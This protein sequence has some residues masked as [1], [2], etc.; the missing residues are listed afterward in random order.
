M[1]DSLS[2]PVSSLPSTSEI[3]FCKFDLV[4]PA[5]LR[6]FVACSFSLEKSCEIRAEDAGKN[7]GLSMG[8][9][10]RCETDM[11]EIEQ[12]V[13]ASSV[14][15]EIGGVMS[16]NSMTD[17]RLGKQSVDFGKYEISLA[18]LLP[19]GVAAG[20]WGNNVDTWTVCGPD[21]TM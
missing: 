17:F 16:D 7:F 10:C 13:H 15:E 3:P 1:Q 20:V 5:A 4:R 6:R 21:L 18:V 12:V 19:G 8:K 14:V 9:S 2:S 11:S